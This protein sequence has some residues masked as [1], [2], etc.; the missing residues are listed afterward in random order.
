MFQTY[1]DVADPT[2][3]AGRAEKLRAEL[4]ARGLDGFIIPRA[5]EHQGEYVPPHAERLRWLTGFSGSA[6]LAIVLQ[7][8]AAIF[9]DGRYTLQVR[10]QSDIDV[11]DPQSIMSM[12]PAQ[13]VEEN[14]VAGAKLAYDP[15]LHT[16]DAVERLKQAAEKAGAELV[17]VET[18][19]IDVVWEDQ[20]EKPAA[21]IQ[22][23]DLAYAGTPATEKLQAITNELQ[24]SDA[25]A[26]IVTM[27]D[28]IAWLFNIRG[29]DVAHSPLP[30]SF[31]IVYEEGHAE[32]FV[33]DEKISAETR[34]HLGNVVTLLPPADLGPTLAKLGTWGREVRI[35]PATCSDWISTRLKESGATIKR[36]T[37][38]CELPKARK[39]DTEVAGTKAA[40]IRD[41]Q[42]L[43]RF[44]AW[45]D[46]ETPGGNVT[47]ISASKQ[48]E[49]FRQETGQL[50]EV[51]FD[52]IS[53]AGPNGAIV[54]YRVTTDTD[55]LLGQGELYLVDS[56]AQYL[57]GTTDVTRTVAI[58]TPSQE[59]K[60]RF[61][62]VLKGHIGLASA[63]FPK[64][65]SGAQLDALARMALW[66]AGLD[67]DHG[68]GHGVGS[69]LSVHEGPQRIS[70]AGHVP[71]DPG[72]IVSDEPGYYK[73]DAFGIRIENLLVVTAPAPI[74]G[75]ER[76][77][78]GFETVTLA[79]IDLALVEEGL[80][81]DDEKAWLNSYHADVRE[82]VSPALNAEE[83]SWL[84]RATRTV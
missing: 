9:I 66:Q 16:V 36:G 60:D 64:G 33:H 40:H 79:P 6:G 5:D 2:L 70:K 25:D 28:S 53:G 3:G 50:K 7:D 41:G 68:T 82:K 49:Q 11:F 57:D 31:A 17:A 81:T 34:T 76:D 44:L 21:P 62:R 22:P 74:E 51:S 15:W 13:W 83:K 20:P 42:A 39:N 80:L 47:E 19:L 84:E 65:T 45:L 78:M 37:D 29:G 71:L 18:N 12:S 23:H 61:T 27:P 24:M 46:R 14:L 73:A 77:M 69:Y 32:L 38:L 10:Y 55:R 52:T 43:S 35:D 72:M 63:R 59:M 67:F 56:G 48:L 8:K 30:L 1:D 58:G 26:A 4:K 75:G 54:H